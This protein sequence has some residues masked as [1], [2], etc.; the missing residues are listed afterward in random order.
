V[1][2]F[3]RLKSSELF[4][5]TFKK[6]YV[7]HTKYFVCFYYPL[8]CKKEV[9]FIASKKVGNAVKR[10]Y[11]K[12][13][14]RALF[15]AQKNIKSGVYVFVAKVNILDVDFYRLQKTFNFAIKKIIN[16]AKS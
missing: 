9:G 4:N 11:A 6:G 7:E 1:N 13:R 10:N 12:R 14:L 3:N 8:S 15:F 2:E 16:K 5:K